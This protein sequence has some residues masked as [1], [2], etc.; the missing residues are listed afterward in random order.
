MVFQKVC[1]IFKESIQIC[2]QFFVEF[3][4]KNMMVLYH[5]L[6]IQT[7][8]N[9]IELT[10]KNVRLTTLY[11]SRLQISY[12]IDR[13][14]PEIGDSLHTTEVGIYKRK[15]ESKKTK[16]HA[17]YQERNKTRCSRPRKRPRKKEKTFFFS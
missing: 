10:L 2:P 11:E 14:Y 17:F 3:D 13:E 5:V 1:N 8:S 9:I 15:Q 4:M 16:R 6:S 12:Y 7:F